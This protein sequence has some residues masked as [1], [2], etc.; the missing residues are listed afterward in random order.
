[1]L[2]HPWDQNE[3]GF[4]CPAC[5]ELVRASFNDEGDLPETCRQCGFPDFEDGPGY[6]TDTPTPASPERKTE[7]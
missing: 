5:G 6:F 4:W 2:K 3:D 1:M 7:R